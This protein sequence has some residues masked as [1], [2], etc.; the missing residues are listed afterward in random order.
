MPALHPSTSPSWADL[1]VDPVPDLRPSALPVYAALR[2]MTARQL[3]AVS[4]TEL[5]RTAAVSLNS[6]SRSMAD[7]TAAGLVEL[8]YGPV[9]GAG[10]GL[11]WRQ[12]RL[13]SC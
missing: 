7:L 5:A 4:R 6:V 12:V 10:S 13:P 11:R 8:R 2:G 3:A 1:G 9:A